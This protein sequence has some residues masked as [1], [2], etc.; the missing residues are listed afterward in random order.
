VVDQQPVDGLAGR[1]RR[2]PAGLGAVAQP[3]G[4]GEPLDGRD[5]LDVG[6]PG[7]GGELLTVER[8]R[9]RLQRVRKH[10]RQDQDAKAIWPGS[11][12]IHER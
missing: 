7:Q 1:K 8:R 10:L 12:F 4:P 3:G 11:R 2:Q 6:H 9:Q 5:H